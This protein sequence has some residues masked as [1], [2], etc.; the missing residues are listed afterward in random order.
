MTS[1]YHLARAQHLFDVAFAPQAGLEIQI[2]Y[3]AVPAQMELAKL[4]ARKQHEV[5]M[6]NSPASPKPQP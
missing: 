2:S 3:E 1:D 5:M 4:E 6:L